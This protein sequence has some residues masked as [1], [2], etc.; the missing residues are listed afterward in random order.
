MTTT[1]ANDS[2]PLL[3]AVCGASAQVLALRTLQ[4]LLE[5][6]QAVELAISMSAQ[7]SEPPL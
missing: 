3:L 2:A 4:L 5:A 6:D 1:P 7:W